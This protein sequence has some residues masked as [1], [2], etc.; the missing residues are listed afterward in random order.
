[1]PNHHAHAPEP[2]PPRE[3]SLT[4]HARDGYPLSA[5]LFLPE[6]VPTGVVLLNA[7]TA[8][9]QTF[10][11]S[12]ARWL[13]ELGFAAMTWD[14]RGFGTSLHGPLRDAKNDICSWG[15]LDAPAIL[16][17]LHERFPDL[18]LTW[19]GH[20]VGAHLPGFI[21]NPQRIQRMLSVASG[22]G[23]WGTL[24]PRVRLKSI[25]LW[26][27]LAPIS[28][29]IVG[30]FPGRRLGILDDVPRGVIAEWRRWSLHPK[31]ML[32]DDEAQRRAGYARYTFPLHMLSFEDD[33]LMTKKSTEFIR[34]LYVNAQITHRRLRPD[35]QSRPVGHLG[36]FRKENRD[37]WE[38]HLQ[39]WLQATPEQSHAHR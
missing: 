38:K 29:S 39:T 36:W 18:P 15:T 19:I 30:Y 14:Y 25:I 8:V 10:Y 9:P 7:A 4:I 12:F 5:N 31:Y 28:T 27:A 11:T 24:N 3:A 37:M 35:E 32:R 33:E 1:M 13:A 26:G 17:A 6:G 16:D 21:D 2:A 34:S 22:S 23:Y 20:S